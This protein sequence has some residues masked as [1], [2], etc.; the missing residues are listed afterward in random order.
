MRSTTPRCEGLPPECLTAFP[1]R[2]A[3][4]SGQ[5]IAKRVLN[6]A[7]L[8]ATSLPGSSSTGG[9]SRKNSRPPDGWVRAAT[10]RSSPETL[11]TLRSTAT[12]DRRTDEVAL[13]SNVGGLLG[14]GLAG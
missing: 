7:A 14:F 5:A 12:L 2:K 6:E 9:A 8:Q 4:S 10:T 1:I 11:P 3:S 13:A